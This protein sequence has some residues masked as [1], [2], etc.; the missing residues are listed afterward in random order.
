MAFMLTPWFSQIE[1]FPMG[2]FAFRVLGGSLGVLGA[3]AAPV[4]WVGMLI[5]CAREDD[6]PLGSK[7]F[8]FIL[9]FTIAWFG[10]S[11]YFFSVYKKQRQVAGIPRPIQQ[12]HI[13]QKRR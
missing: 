4:I 9:F 13:Q 6:S 7:V 2:K 11:A 10:S 1:T 3:L 5:Y 8:W 12:A